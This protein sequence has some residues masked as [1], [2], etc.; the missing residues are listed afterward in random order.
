MGKEM[1][2]EAASK[3]LSCVQNPRLGEVPLALAGFVLSVDTCSGGSHNL[4]PMQGKLSF[5]IATTCARSS[6]EEQPSSSERLQ[7]K[8]ELC[9]WG[10]SL[11]WQCLLAAGLGAWGKHPVDMPSVFKD[12]QH[13]STTK[14]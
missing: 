1:K 7:S 11:T 4:L 2:C 9:V 8:V 13:M 5:C 12:A 3:Q 14:T 10:R 6:R